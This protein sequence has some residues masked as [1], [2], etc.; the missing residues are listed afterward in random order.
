MDRFIYHLLRWMARRFEAAWQRRA[1]RKR[2][3]A[4]DP[5]VE[6]LLKAMGLERVSAQHDELFADL[7]ELGFFRR[8]A[9]RNFRRPYR[10]RVGAHELAIFDYEYCVTER[11]GMDEDETWYEQT[12]FGFRNADCAFPIIDQTRNTGA[13]V[14]GHGQRVIF[15][16]EGVIF[17]PDE[18]EDM[19]QECLERMEK[20][21]QKYAAATPPAEEPE[22]AAKRKRKKRRPPDAETG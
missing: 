16:V 17:E 20:L 14:Y 7:R 8:G 13:C 19:L 10:G 2:Q 5:A 15:Y 1:K 18:L 11:A 3:E 21:R 6:G 9:R 22:P 12:I 4:R